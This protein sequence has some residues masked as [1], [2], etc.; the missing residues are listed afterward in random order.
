MYIAIHYEN[1]QIWIKM[2][3]EEFRDLLVKELGEPGNKALDKIIE[4]LKRRTING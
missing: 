2:T 3:P 4:E 1:D